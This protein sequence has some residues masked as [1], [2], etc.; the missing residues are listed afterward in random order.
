M[1]DSSKTALA[2]LVTIFLILAAWSYATGPGG[3]PSTALPPLPALL[4]ALRI[5]WIEGRLLPHI[6]FTAQAA[7]LGLLIGAA[8]GMALGALVVVIPVFEPF[9]VPLVVGMQSIPKIALA[10]LIVAYVGFGMES[11]IFTAALLSFFPLFIAMVRGLRSID[12]LIL[13]LY[14]AYSASRLHILLNARIPAATPFLFAGLKVAIVLSL[15]G[16]VVSEFVASTRGLGYIIKS[17]S[18]EFDVSMMFVAIIS[19]SIMGVVATLAVEFA[20]ARIVFWRK[21]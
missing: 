12:P 11:K 1:I 9:V 17:R 18:Q 21:R 20:Q 13:D 4:D 6:L 16:C 14:R 8:L 15:I 10:P 5:G 3:L 2:T 7:A 19:L